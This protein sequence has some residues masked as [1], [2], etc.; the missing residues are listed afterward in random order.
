MLDGTQFHVVAVL[1]DGF[2][3]RT[4]P[5]RMHLRKDMYRVLEA[6]FDDAG[7]D[8]DAAPQV[9]R[10][11]GVVLLVPAGG[12]GV[13]LAGNFVW[14]LD[15][16]LRE[17]SRQYTAAHQ[18]RLR[19]GLSQGLCH[20]DGRAWLGEPID[21]AMQLAHEPAARERSAAGAELVLVVSGD[22]HRAIVKHG[23]RQIDTAG[24]AQVPGDDG[25]WLLAPGG[26][27][28]EE[29]PPAPAPVGST[30]PDVFDTV[31]AP[32]R[33]FV[34]ALPAMIDPALA[35]PD[36]LAWMHRVLG[37][38]AAQL[39]TQQQSRRLAAGVVE[40]H[41]LRGT[42]A[43]LEKL[44]ALR[45]GIRAEVRDP[46]SSTWSSTPLP[47]FDTAAD[48]VVVVRVDTD[49]PLPGVDEVIRAALPVH[50]GYRIERRR[51]G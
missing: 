17:R 11:D 38:E 43:G 47:R 1:I 49:D 32:V 22:F 25:A 42:A 9:D 33:E 10:H 15:R 50:L 19:L 51:P 39:L 27:E 48:R 35:P 44:L 7:L 45:Y 18:L 20:H 14:V 36:A 41:A 6:A 13:V 30:P 29:P 8:W 46:G 34:D 23:Y 26:A 4:N 2:A 24:F 37:T 16:G 5:E 28:A 40:C 12:A 31:I 3:Q 21:V